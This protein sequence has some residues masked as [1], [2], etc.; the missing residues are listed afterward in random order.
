MMDINHIGAPDIKSFWQAEAKQSETGVQ[1]GYAT[2]VTVTWLIVERKADN[3][4]RK[5]ISKDSQATQAWDG[6]AAAAAAPSAADD[7]FLTSE[8]ER[9]IE[10]VCC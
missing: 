9:L 5:N 1:S 3:I 4:P 6:N 8:L 7:D 10:E 2:S